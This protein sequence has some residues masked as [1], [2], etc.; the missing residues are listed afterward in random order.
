MP[1]ALVLAGGGLAG[2][3][4]E[5]GVLRGLADASPEATR[6]LLDASTTF[7]GTSAGSAV[8]AQLSTGTGLEESYEAQLQEESAEIGADIDGE[9]LKA[10][11]AAVVEGASS[12]Q[13]AR[14]RIGTLAVEAET[15]PEDTRRAVISARMGDADWP[16]Q[17]LLITAVDTATGELRVFDRENG[18]ALV[19][20]ISA[21]C[22]VPGVWPPVSIDG[23][24]YMDGGVR[25][26]SNADLAA[27]AD[28]V[29]VITPLPGVG[30]P[31]A[32]LIPTGELDA[33]AES[34]VEVLYADE[35]SVR[36]FGPN[37]LD[38]AVR[39]A[40]ARAGRAQ[41]ARV[42]ARIAALVGAEEPGGV[43]TARCS[44]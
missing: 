24:R 23:V 28:W 10:L 5:L 34:R 30:T 17:R 25:S 19:D 35:E 7:I 32:G 26:G 20:A 21:S 40:S 44:A 37:S 6:L 29:L 43:S 39:A 12:P 4:W 33:L 2:I 42:A 15:L 36:A 22:A 14:R 8:A 16:E 38:P 41:G 3:A 13:D 9:R 27:G 18:V 11:F 1:G 31:G